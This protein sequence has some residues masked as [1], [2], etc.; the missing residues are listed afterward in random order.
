MT[1]T[2]K[3]ISRKLEPAELMKAFEIWYLVSR[4]C[5]DPKKRHDDYLAS[6]LAEFGKVRVPK[7]EGEALNKALARIS[8]LSVSQLPEIS[9]VPESWR[10]VAALHRELARQSANGMYFLGC[11]D[12][13]KAHRS[14]NKDSAN[15]IN[16]A[17][18]PLGVL[19]IVKT[20]K[21][22][23]GGDASEFRYLLPLG[24]LSTKSAAAGRTEHHCE[25]RFD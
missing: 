24:A 19:S 11:R 10:W 6:F 1:A 5:L 23:P 21:M 7:G 8:T 2:Q 18:E 12:T 16:R 3:R 25:I 20:G 22:R 4:P 15:N 14:L 17:L 9:G 13:A